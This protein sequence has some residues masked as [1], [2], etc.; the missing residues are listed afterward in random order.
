M[1]NILIFFFLSFSLFAQKNNDSRVLYSLKGNF[2]PINLGLSVEGNYYFKADRSIG[3]E[4]HS[5]QF[6]SSI[7]VPEGF[8]IDLFPEFLQGYVE[9]YGGGSIK[10]EKIFHKPKEKIQYTLST[11]LGISSYRKVVGYTTSASSILTVH[12]KVYKHFVLPEAMVGIHFTK[13]K[14]T[15]NFYTGFDVFSNFR[16]TGVMLKFGIIIR[17]REK[18]YK[19]FP[20]S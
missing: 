19:D 13:A 5:H 18:G 1:N 3:I 8:S 12:S 17:K 2:S 16:K 9:D 15:C 6:K 14:G 11:G 10:Y 7:Y 4:V 20:R